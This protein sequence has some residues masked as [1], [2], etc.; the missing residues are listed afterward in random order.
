[1]ELDF[2]AGGLAGLGIRRHYLVQM[3]V[4]IV[5]VDSVEIQEDFEIHFPLEVHFPSEE[6]E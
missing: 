4:D 1:M 5:V 3:L 6:E 2:A